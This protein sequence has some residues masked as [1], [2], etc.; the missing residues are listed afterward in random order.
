MDDVTVAR[1]LHVF[2]VVLWIGG[3]GFVTTVLLPTLKGHDAATRF[4]RLDRFEDRFAR[5]ARW[6]VLLAGATGLYMTAR[7]D[8]WSRFEDVGFWWMHA[9]VLTWLAFA[10][11]LFVIEPLGIERRIRAKTDPEAAF[12]A[13]ERLHRVLLALALITVLGAVLG[14]HGISWFG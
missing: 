2:A 14:V 6:L 3:V 1:A 5:Q 9:M 13:I 10:A 8:L 12:R 11:M 7:L 4:R